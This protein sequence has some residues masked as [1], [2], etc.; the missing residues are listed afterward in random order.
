MENS[1]F[2]DCVSVFYAVL[3]SAF[4]ALGHF[5]NFFFTVNPNKE[6]QDRVFSWIGL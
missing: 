2:Q 1:D 3:F 6:T 4:A 5:F